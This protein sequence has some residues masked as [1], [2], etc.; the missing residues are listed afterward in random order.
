M[1]QATCDL[2]APESA[3]RVT[4]DTPRVSRRRLLAVAAASPA[5]VAPALSPAHPDPLVALGR[6]FF[7][8]DDHP[9]WYDDAPELVHEYVTGRWGEIYETIANTQ[10]RSIAGLAVKARM[11]RKEVT[12]GQSAY[13]EMLVEGLIADAERLAAQLEGAPA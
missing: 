13:G 10:A 5:L 12:D 8:L 9:G 11:V 7:Y 3:L 6:E 2:I 1:A 4:T